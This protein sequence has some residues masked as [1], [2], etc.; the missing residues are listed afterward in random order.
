[1]ARLTSQEVVL[2]KARRV[3]RLATA[4]AYGAPH[5]IPICFAYDG[6]HFYSV[7]DCK[8]KRTS[9]TRLKRV[10]NIL[11]NGS[12]ALV[13]DHYEEDWGRLWYVLV[14]GTAMLIYE[15]D[16]HQRSISL[17]KEKYSQYRNMDIDENPVIKITPARITSWGKVP[18]DE[19]E[20]NRE[21]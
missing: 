19:E 18:Q 11:S 15:G 12:V 7:L 10:R 21:R 9:L 3:A 8:P 6:E 16:E 1:M 13:L 2:I 5:L 4:D 14:T 17:L 20:R